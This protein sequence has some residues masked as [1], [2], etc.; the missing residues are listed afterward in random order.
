MRLEAIPAGIVTVIHYSTDTDYDIIRRFLS[1]YLT[2]IAQHH[3]L[4]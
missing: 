2:S 1:P 3:I 4:L